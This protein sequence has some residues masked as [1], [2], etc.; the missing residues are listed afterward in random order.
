MPITGRPR[1]KDLYE[2][3]Q[4]ELMDNLLL[5]LK[6]DNHNR[7]VIIE[8]M[9]DEQ[10]QEL[11]DISKDIKK[12]YKCGQWP[13]FIHGEIDNTYVSLIKT[14]LKENGYKFNLAYVMEDGSKKSRKRGF[15]INKK[16]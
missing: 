13:Y 7:I 2:K 3:E 5:I 8:D 14:M 6:I 12:Y 4:I 9:T 16:D 15:Y 10:K 11:H 1:K